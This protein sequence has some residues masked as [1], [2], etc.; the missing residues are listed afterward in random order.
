MLLCVPL[1]VAVLREKKFSDHGFFTAFATATVP[2]TQETLPANEELFGKVDA[3]EL[4]QV[5]DCPPHTHTHPTHVF[6]VCR[7]LM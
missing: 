2:L 1:D 7:S 4:V 6:F 5:R 3:T